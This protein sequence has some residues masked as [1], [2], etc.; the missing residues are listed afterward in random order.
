VFKVFRGCDKELGREIVKVTQRMPG[1]V[2]R[3]S[4][5]RDEDLHHRDDEKRHPPDD[6]FADGF[7][8]DYLK[9]LRR[10]ESQTEKDSPSSSFSG[11]GI[12][13][14]LLSARAAW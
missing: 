14:A 13:A 3:R 1:D 4:P 7:A 9:R 12:P 8:Q 6:E 10:V 11:S 5:V 2:G